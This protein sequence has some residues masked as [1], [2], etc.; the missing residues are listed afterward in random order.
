[1]RLNLGSGPV[2]VPGWTNID[3]S[4]NVILDRLPIVKRALFKLGV[5]TDQHMVS[6]DRAIK[7][8]DIRKLPYAE[9]IVDA[10]YSSHTL[11]HLYLRDAERVIAECARVLRPGGILRLALPDAEQWARDLVAGVGVNGHDAGTIFNRRLDAH[12]E[13][14]PGL[15]QRL[16]DQ[17]GGHVHRW[18]PSAS[19]VRLMLEEAGFVNVSRCDFKNGSLPDL[20]NVETKPISFFLEATKPSATGTAL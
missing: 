10:V 18:Q 1:V 11:E 4:P 9:G 16:R 5:L 3:R 12:P 14:R 15:L 17:S 20:E 6:W 8:H 19:H 2:A 7:R 13:E